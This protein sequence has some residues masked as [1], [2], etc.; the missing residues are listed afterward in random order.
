MGKGQTRSLA[1]RFMR[2][3]V[4]AAAVTAFFAFNAA[5]DLA[6]ADPSLVA[7]SR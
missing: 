2:N 6:R 4:A 5:N 7:D 3:I 1:A